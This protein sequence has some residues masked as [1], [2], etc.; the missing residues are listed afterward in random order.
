MGYREPDFTTV[1][2]RPN[3]TMVQYPTSGMFSQTRSH[4]IPKVL[5]ACSSVGVVIEI[6]SY[7]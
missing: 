6:K 5:I 7:T 1:E 2:Q 3:Y 4:V